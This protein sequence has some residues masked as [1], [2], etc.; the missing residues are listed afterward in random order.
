[1]SGSLVWIALAAGEFLL[2]IFL[3][4]LVSWV[5]HRAM[6]RRDQKAIKELVAY[7]RGRKDERLGEISEFLG[8]KYAMEGDEQGYTAR[9]LYKAEAGL[10]QSFARTYLNRDAKSALR[11]HKPVQ[12]GFGEYWKLETG[13]EKG[14]PSA[15]EDLAEL[16]AEAAAAAEQAAEEGGD[17]V[18]LDRLRK[19]NQSL[20]DE[21]RLT[22]ETMGRMLNEYSSV[23]SKDADL[24]DIQVIGGEAD[25]DA[26]PEETQQE[27]AA[28]EAAENDE[29]EGDAVTE[30]VVEPAEVTE[31]FAE[32]GEAVAEV[33]P[34]GDATDVDAML[35]EAMLEAE[36]PVEE[37][38]DV[39]LE[40]ASDADTEPGETAQSDDGSESALQ[41]GRV[42]VA[43][44]DIDALLQ[45]A[46]ISDAA[47]DEAEA[48]P[49]EDIDELIKQLDKD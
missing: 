8:E 7:Y 47:E 3:A 9:T 23:F 4:L 11:F 5:R 43:A 44:D 33:E 2:I 36:T 12:E 45:D 24:G 37:D 28:V 20:S 39:A 30:D 10:I 29:I 22:M 41:E 19:E 27:S 13:A 1:M 21:L 6:K 25:L 15:T 14:E 46:G 34:E 49:D 26:M 38:A 48:T 16:E 18:E 31:A 17:A 42:D 35:E 32:A 40:T